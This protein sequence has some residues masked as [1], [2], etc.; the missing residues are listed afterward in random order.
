MWEAKAA[1]GRGADLHAWALEV[2][3]PA[4]RGAAGLQRSELFTAPGERVLVVTWWA[5]EPLALPEPPAA[6][7]ARPVHRWSFTSEHVE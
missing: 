3:V 4:V 2:A 7:L 1:E 6:L 5:G